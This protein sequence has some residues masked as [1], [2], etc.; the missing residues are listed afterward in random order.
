MHIYARSREGE[1]KN[2]FHF[3]YGIAATDAHVQRAGGH[4]SCNKQHAHDLVY[5]KMIDPTI[6]QI[7]TF[8]SSRAHTHKKILD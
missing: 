4:H 8:S 3:C 6:N 1:V 7:L 5:K 2:A